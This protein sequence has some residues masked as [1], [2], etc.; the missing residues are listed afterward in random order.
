[1][2]F[3]HLSVLSTYFVAAAALRCAGVLESWNSAVAVAAAA[4]PDLKT[5]TLAQE[6]K[7]ASL[8]TRE[9]LFKAMHERSTGESYFLAFEP[10]YS[11]LLLLKT[12]NQLKTN[13][14]ASE[15][16]AIFPPDPY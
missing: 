6:C 8:T 16:N 14:S 2:P 15:R 7:C 4:L 3:P 13:S 5:T 9:F 10:P 11:T 12:R 1:M